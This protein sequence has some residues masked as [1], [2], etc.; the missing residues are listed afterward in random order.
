MV[1]FLECQGCKAQENIMCQD[2]KSA[3]LLEKNG[4]ASASK[5]TR[6]VN[7][8]CFQIKDHT[9]E[10]QLEVK[11]CRTDDMIGDYMTKG[12]Q[13]HKFSKFRKAIM[14]VE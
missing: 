8:R 7:A 3:I 11:H 9:D 14:G 1:M 13:G 5:R 4:R 12:L 2:D 10:K 6:A